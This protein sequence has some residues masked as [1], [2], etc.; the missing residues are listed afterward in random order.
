MSLKPFEKRDTKS[1]SAMRDVLDRWRLT[2][3][4]I[5]RHQTLQLDGHSVAWWFDTA[6]AT[7]IQLMEALKSDRTLVAPGNP[8]GSTLVTV[9]LRFSRPMGQRLA[10]D[11]E[12][13][14]TWILEGC[15]IPP[16]ENRT[17]RESKV[18]EPIT[19]K[20]SVFDYESL[21]RA[22]QFH[23]LLNIEDH[24]GFL[25]H[26][27]EIARTFFRGADYGADPLYAEFPYTEDTFDERMKAIY[28]GFV[29]TM[30][31]PHWMDTGIIR[32]PD[33]Q[34]RRRTYNVGAF[35]TRVVKARTRQF[36]PFNLVDGA[37]L[38]NILTVGP[39]D[40]VQS[41]LFAIW[42][43]E[44]GNGKIEQNHSN[45]FD[46]LLRSIG[47]YMPSI[48]AEAFIEQS[49]LPGAYEGAVF[50][51]CVGQYPVEFFPE[52]LG[53][54]LHLEWEATPTLTPTVRLY[55]GRALN[56]HYYQLHVAIDNISVGHGALAKDAIKRYLAR[57]R[58][59][60]GNTA[61]QA[62]WKRIWNGYVTWATLGGFGVEMIEMSLAL[63]RKQIN[64]S[65]DPKKPKCFPDLK[66]YFKRQMVE[67]VRRKAPFAK[68]VHGGKA[69]GGKPL[70]SLFEQPEELLNLLVNHRLVDPHNPRSSRLIQLTK[71]DGPMYEIFTEEE[72]DVILDWIESLRDGMPSH[73]VDPDDDGAPSGWPEKMV[74]VI[75]KY[76]STGQAVHQGIQ[77]PD[78]NGQLVPLASLLSQPPLIMAALTRGGWVVPGDP[79]RSMFLTRIL[80]N[81][82]PMDGVMSAQEVNIVTSWIRDGAKLPDAEKLMKSMLVHTKI[83]RLALDRPLIG[84]GAVH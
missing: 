34:G 14:K 24:P 53:M 41:N 12:T 69:L 74:E 75:Q 5:G 64:V 60:G 42:D 49:F 47:I 72:L 59:E 30:Y 4:S 19:S 7:T 13:I 16:E 79:N 82:G 29:G 15:P 58:V 68:Q 31:L 38:Q 62:A 33:D 21:T 51:L 2:A 26:G 66:D 32:F 43:D 61:V 57:V 83:S 25:P 70:N 37:W 18:L 45:V 46:S 84:M 48:R 56:P 44:A 65:T 81:G 54:T 28:D 73:C 1:A 76:S 9:Y 36:A 77:L 11:A 6:N 80:T 17:P 63:D 52:L 39:G 23:V 67:L 3:L 55:K 35:S 27:R 78:E 20:L 40:D 10:A 8:D 22:E 71:Y 50:Q